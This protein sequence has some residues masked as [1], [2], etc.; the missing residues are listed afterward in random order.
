MTCKS[1]M[2]ARGGASLWF[3]VGAW[4]EAEATGWGIVALAGY[5]LIAAVFAACWLLL[6][7]LPVSVRPEQNILP[8]LRAWL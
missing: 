8:Y 1:I 7:R 2:N 3:K 4:F 6:G 5:A